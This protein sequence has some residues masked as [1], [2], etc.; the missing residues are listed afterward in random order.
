MTSV[1]RAAARDAE[2]KVQRNWAFV[3]AF[4]SKPKQQRGST[5]R[6]PSTSSETGGDR[7]DCDVKFVRGET[8]AH[9]RRDVLRSRRRSEGPVLA[10]RRTGPSSN[11]KRASTLNVAEAKNMMRSTGRRKTKRHDEGI[12]RTARRLEELKRAPR[13]PRPQHLQFSGPRRRRSDL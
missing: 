6:T 11:N 1:R 2:V 3:T 7:C 8:L 9:L 12:L 13:G 10:S 4:V 5:N